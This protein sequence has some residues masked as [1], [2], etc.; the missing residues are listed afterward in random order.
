MAHAQELASHAPPVLPDLED[1]EEMD[2]RE[3]ERLEEL[4]DAITLAESADQ[5]RD[6]TAWNFRN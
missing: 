3:R 6:E 1:L 2:D 4:L 5:V